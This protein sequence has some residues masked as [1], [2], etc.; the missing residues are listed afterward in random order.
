MYIPVE[1]PTA[2]A[3]PTKADAFSKSNAVK[4]ATAT[5]ERQEGRGTVTHSSV[6]EKGL[7][8]QTNFARDRTSKEKTGRKEEEEEKKESGKWKVLA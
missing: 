3:A 2:T 6:L 4:F 8:E 1:Y 5:T 7:V